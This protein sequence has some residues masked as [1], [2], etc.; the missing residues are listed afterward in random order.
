VE[1]ECLRVLRGD[2]DDSRRVAADGFDVLLAQPD[3]PPAPEAF[4]GHGSQARPSDRD[5]VPEAGGVLDDLLVEPLPESSQERHGDRPPDDAEDREERAE[6]LTPNVTH[7]L[8]QRI[9][10]GQHGGLLPDIPSPSHF[11]VI[12]SDLSSEASAKEE[13]RD[14]LLSGNDR[15]RFLVAALLGMT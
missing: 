6:L 15:S 1:V 5:A 2:G 4:V 12:P 7:H 8:P 11:L 3:A 13:A 9:L 10:E 14:L